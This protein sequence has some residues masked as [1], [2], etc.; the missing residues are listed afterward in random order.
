AISGTADAAAR[1]GDPA[2]VVEHAQE[3]D[4]QPARGALGVA[5]GRPGPRKEDRVSFTM[6]D[7]RAIFA[8]A[9][10]APQAP[11]RSPRTLP[12]AGIPG[13]SPYTSSA[14]RF[15]NRFV[16][17]NDREI[18]RIQPL[19]D[20]T[21]ALEA[22]YEAMSDEEIRAAFAEL[23]E[24]SLEAAKPDDPSEDELAH[25]DLERR[26][27]LKKERRR[28]ENARLQLAL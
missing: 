11:G 26:R 6:G 24:D 17:S 5:H 21:N 25:P 20:E 14:M 22:E 13:E 27:E 8:D 9:D 7:T 2:L 15:L 19:V 16:D 3:L 4:Q 10:G 12:P 1:A 28:R 23:R 18:R